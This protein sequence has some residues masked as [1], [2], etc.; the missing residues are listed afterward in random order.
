MPDDLIEAARLDGAHGWR[1]QR[2]IVIPLLTPQLFFLL[3]TGTIHALQSFGQIHI[4]TRGGPNST[5][6]TLVYSIYD[7]A[8][9]NNNSHFGYASAQAIVLLA[10]VVAI[11][12]VQFGV[13]ERKVFYR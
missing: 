10:V 3:V 6:T 4:L 8:F 1:L 7:Q 5:T 13:L 11:T 12:A 9:A 2:S